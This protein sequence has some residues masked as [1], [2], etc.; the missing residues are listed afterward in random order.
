MALRK[1]RAAI[2]SAALLAGVLLSGCAGTATLDPQFT[3]QADSDPIPKSVGVTYS[4]EL[5]AYETTVVPRIHEGELTLPLGHASVSL[6]RRVF[7]SIFEDV[8][9]AGSRPSP[10]RR[11][12]RLDAVIE[13]RIDD[14]TFR[15]LRTGGWR[16][17]TVIRYSLT[18]RAP[19]GREIAR[20]TVR[21]SSAVADA[22]DRWVWS[23][24]TILERAIESAMQSAV[25]ALAAS[26]EEVPEAVRWR[27]G[28]PVDAGT[29]PAAG[30]IT[31]F[32]PQSGEY[33]MRGLY[34]SV[35]AVAADPYKSPDPATENI[36]ADLRKAGA[37][38]FLL[39]VENLGGRRLLFRRPEIALRFPDGTAL[40][41]VSGSYLSAA[42]TT[43]RTRVGGIANPPGG[44]LAAAIVG[45]ANLIILLRNQGASE[46]ETAQATV[47]ELLYRSDE[48]KDGRL[49][50]GETAQGYV[51][52]RVPPRLREAEGMTLSVP[53]VD[54]D[55]ATRYVVSLPLGPVDGYANGGVIE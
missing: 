16:F 3:P 43:K 7:P 31:E 17:W 33:R 18:I 1:P 41:P 13:P 49:G 44:G 35:V 6:L 45:V 37:F 15:A 22:D 55:T 46:S 48:L 54:L 39:A 4:P 42:L 34:E 12:A 11:L 29:A 19:D 9:E 2:L 47:Y 14:F 53:V 30:Q 32:G 25:Q 36:M 10:S 26:F 27:R 40:E 20:W 8:V 23:S 5:R 50:P 51:H 38:S 52:F 28:Q 24:H 21:G